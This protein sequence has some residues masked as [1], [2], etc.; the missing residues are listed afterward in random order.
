MPSIKQNPDLAVSEFREPGNR[1]PD[2]R[3]LGTILRILVFVNLLALIAAIMQT[4]SL[5]QVMPRLAEFS[6]FLQPVLL[7]SLLLFYVLWPLLR[8]FPYYAG[9]GLILLCE[10]GLASFMHQT[11]VYLFGVQALPPLARVCLLTLLTVLLV[12]GYFSLRQR[13]LSPAISEARMQA[14]QARIRPHFLFNSIN[15]VLSIVRSDP[16]RAETALEDLADLFRVLMADNRELVPLAQE[17]A[18]CRQYLALEK[19]R[20]E[21]RLR[22]EWQ[23]DSIPP[24]ALIP[25][26]ILQPLLENAVYHGIELLPEGGTLKI[27]MEANKRE[28]RISLHNPLAE[29]GQQHS[30]NGM[31]LNNIRERLALHFDA[32]ASLDCCSEGDIYRVDIVIPYRH[33]ALL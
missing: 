20:L 1:L 16:G 26:L 18:L 17:I 13:A 25:P 7:L 30:G 2:L 21:E 5:D 6:V 24:D 11:G 10:L 31:A 22:V 27:H 28:I 29:N 3:N 9:A 15:A 23:I 19:L 14:L 8:R 33:P 4:S 12:L 32:E